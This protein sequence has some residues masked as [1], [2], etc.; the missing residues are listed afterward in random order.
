VPVLVECFQRLDKSATSTEEWRGGLSTGAAL[1]LALFLK[2]SYFLVALALVAVSLMVWFP[3]VRR[4]LGILAGFSAVAFLVMAYLRFNLPAMLSALRMAAGARA[5][6]LPLNSPIHKIATNLTPLFCVLALA[7]AAS[8]LKPRM[9]EWMG[10]FHLP[11]AAV[12]VFI[13]D[14]ALLTTNSQSSGLPLLGVFAL[15]IADRLA[16]ARADL[17]A[18]HQ[19]ALPYYAS[20]LLLSGLLFLPQFTSD[21][22]ALPIAGVRK[23]HPPQGCGVRFAEPRVAA[24]IL[25][26]HPDEDE[27]QK[28]SN[29]RDYT[30]YVNDGVAL[31]RAHCKPTDKVLVMDMQNPFP[32]VLGWVP[33]RGGL[34]ATA[35]NYTFSARFRPSFDEYFADTTVVMMPEHPALS[36]Q[37]SKG[38]YEIYGPAV[39]QRFVFA[40]ESDWFRLYKRK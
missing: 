5:Q 8:F 11:V 38:I 2:A 10:D 1:A 19:F 33:P 28:W 21:V 35:F 15:L 26:D 9:L 37:F 29:G 32:Y 18:A 6:T 36:P 34:A 40:A 4:F 39:E 13:A 14:I 31:F 16:D 27:L 23:I 22:V 7:V 24:L 17:P 3:S 12:I 20:V 30:T 25:C